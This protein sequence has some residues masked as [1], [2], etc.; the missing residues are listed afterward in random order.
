MGFTT[1]N[2]HTKNTSK[3]LKAVSTKTDHTKTVSPP[4]LEIDF[5]IDSAATVIVLKM[6]RGIKI[7]NTTNYN[8]KNQHLFSEHQLVLNFNQ[9]EQ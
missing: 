1:Y 6:I 4:H 9:M 7:M 2:I 3:T 8:G 5:M